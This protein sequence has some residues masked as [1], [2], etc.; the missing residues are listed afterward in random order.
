MFTSLVFQ[1][2]HNF[3]VVK[4]ILLRKSSNFVPLCLTLMP[5]MVLAFNKSNKFCCVQAAK[6]KTQKMARIKFR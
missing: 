1:P 3:F 4:V 6:I 5:Y 2:F